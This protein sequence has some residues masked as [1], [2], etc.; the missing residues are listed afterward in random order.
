MF[1]GMGF[2]MRLTNRRHGS[3]Q[4]SALIVAL[5]ILLM[6]SVLGISAMRTSIFSSKV[7]TGIQADTM[8]FDAAE[9]AVARSLRQLRG[10]TEAE[11]SKA[12]L[13]GASLQNCLLPDGALK[14]GACGESD[15]MDS[16]ELL[17]AGTYIVHLKNNCRMVS[18]SDVE[19]YRD[20]V[21]DVL[22]QSNMQSYEIENN[23]LQE[24][25]K[26]GLDCIQY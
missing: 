22:G 5:I 24:A 1:T 23:H 6:V 9:S 18:G 21:I 15:R 11:L 4:G 10:F 8:T 16:R 17:Q 2:D 19:L 3:Q 25:L 20:Y 26:V 14:D 12:V 7:A 13:N